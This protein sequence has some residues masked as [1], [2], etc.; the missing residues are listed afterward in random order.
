[1]TNDHRN[2][3]RAWLLCAVLACAGS[4]A[5]AQGAPSAAAGDLEKHAQDLRQELE[6]ARAVQKRAEA[7]AAGQEAQLAE[8][9]EE[10]RA[11]L[12]AAIAQN[13]AVAAE[14]AGHAADIE[15][16]VAALLKEIDAIKAKLP[17]P[18]PSADPAEL[19]DK[20]WAIW[21]K[22][23]AAELRALIRKGEAAVGG[24]PDKWTR[25]VHQQDGGTCAVVA[26]QQMLQRWKVPIADAKGKAVPADKWDAGKLE[27]RLY[28]LSV[29]KGYWV[30][31]TRQGGGTD[32][33]KVGDILGEFGLSPRELGG[34]K[35]SLPDIAAPL[36]KGEAVMV[37]VDAGM[38]WRQ[39]SSVGGAHA[40]LVT[41][42]VEDKKGEVLAVYINDSGRLDAADRG[43]VLV[44][45]ELFG[46]AW[47]GDGKRIVAVAPPAGK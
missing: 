16:R 22:R 40:V 36:K 43:K 32:L 27:T 9:D 39:G 1:M 28:E 38:L 12:R 31:G 37:T 44:P 2:R 20:A 25:L 15:R 10:G 34:G 17:A 24:E 8:A 45:A 21:Y 23:R 30:G 11:L 13:R 3:A 4:V 26:P 42:V 7:T 14:A 33:D 5:P 18:A 29:D 35:L 46:Y 6:R 47:Y 19:G 41:G